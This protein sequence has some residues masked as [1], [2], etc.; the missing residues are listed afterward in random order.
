M[1]MGAILIMIEYY[2]LSKYSKKSKGCRVGW[3][4]CQCGDLREVFCVARLWR[5]EQSATAA[6]PH[7]AILTAL[8][9][10]FVFIC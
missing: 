9:F 10:G 8:V 5:C 6:P 2:A 3:S 7:I 4:N 1:E